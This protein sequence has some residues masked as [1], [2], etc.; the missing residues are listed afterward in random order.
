M[1]ILETTFAEV[2]LRNPLILASATTGWDGHGCRQAWLN[3]A[4]AVVPK[5]FAPP[6]KFQLH[7]RCGRLKMIRLDKTAIGMINN[8]LYTTM[9]LEEWLEKELD[10]AH[11]DETAII[12][13]IVAQPDPELTAANAKKIEGRFQISHFFDACK[14]KRFHWKF[15][16]IEKYPFLISYDCE[17]ICQLKIISAGKF[18]A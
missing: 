18:G 12:A 13:S 4:G 2:K 5:T 15:V 14:I 16:I 3:Q 10:I 6:D 17:K 7:P 8:E 9:T 1:S 11:Q